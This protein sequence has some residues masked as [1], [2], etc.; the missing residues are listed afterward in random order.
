METSRGERTRAFRGGDDVTISSEDPQMRYQIFVSIP[1]GFLYPALSQSFFF[2]AL[3]FL[4]SYNLTQAAPQDTT[5]IGISS[6]ATGRAFDGVGGLS[7]G[8][9]TSR[10]LWDYPAQQRNEILD[11][12]FKPNY[13][14]SLQILKVEIGDDA[15]STNGAEASHMRSRVD[16]NYNRGYEWWLME[17]AKLRNPNI[18][19]YGLE[20]GGLGWF[21]GGMWS[22]DNINY[23]ISWIK[24]AQSDHNLHINYIGGWNE[25]GW[26]KG[27]FEN[28]KKALQNNGL[29]TQVVAADNGWN[30]AGDLASDSVFKSA[31]DIMGVHYPCG[32]MAPEQNCTDNTYTSVAEGL[33][34]RIWASES[35]SQNYDN[36]AIPLARALN[37]DYIDSRMT[38]YI[39]W[40]LIAA[41]YRTLPYY[42]DGLMLADQPWSGYY[43]VGKSI[44]VMAH[45]AQF[46]QTGWQYVDSGCGYFGGSRA[47]G[48]YVTLKS[49]DNKDYSVIV[50]TVDANA[51]QTATFSVD[52]V[53]PAGAVHVWSTNLNSSNSSD[54]FVQ[55]NDIVPNGGSYSITFQPGY[56]YTLST[57]TGQTKGTAASPASA[58]LGLPYTENFEEDS[59][60]EIPKYF[61]SIQGAFEVDSSR[62]GRS[63]H[64]MRQEI[65][66]APL[67]WPGG[68]PT[69]PLVVVGDPGWSNYVVSTDALLE[70][71]GY[72]DLI[73]HL[74]AQSEGSPGASQGYH[75]RI[76]NGGAWTL[77]KEDISGND[78]QLGSGTKQFLLNS[79]HNFSLWFNADSI[80]AFI[81]SS[82]V[83]AVD[84]G[85]YE[86]GQVGLL[87]SKWQNAEFDNLSVVSTG[88]GGWFSI[89]DAVSGAAVDEFNYVGSGWQHCTECG[90]DLYDESNSWDNVANDF[91]TVSFNSTQ[92]KFYGVRD[93]RHGI[94]AISIDGGAETTID[95]YS[96]T[97]LGNQLL[98]TSPVLP[99]GD[100][101]FKLRVTGNKNPSSSDAWTVPDRVD[102]LEP[103]VTGVLQRSSVPVSYSLFQNYPN[104]FNPSTTIS[105]TLKYNGK[106]YLSVYDILGRE[107]A[108]LANELQA[109]GPHEVKF[110]TAGLSSGIYFYKL[111][112]GGGVLTRKMMLLK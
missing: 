32:W 39:N 45:T 86:S 22:Q 51:P 69:A 30:I 80:R 107:V 34:R 88:G 77:F 23:I 62:S 6:T 101:V 74:G 53:L 26:D 3:L 56:V 17:Q 95:F 89:D 102:I 90:T 108:V 94:G 27:W 85:T 96:A 72:I 64:C 91:V 66:L 18:K 60:G 81:D 15:N 13:G 47:N 52:S 7:G 103:A 50:E 112:S 11:Y 5:D 63:G 55:N 73:G 37:R 68:S 12:L 59:L 82:L 43:H 83:A 70:Q 76:T 99:A 44:W 10:L 92:I 57:S 8:G 97:R 106:V 100:H 40:S 35:G 24:H 98:W 9:G 78:T 111:Q 4:F 105:Y 31:V 1:K 2:C 49:P 54:Y 25:S 61:D 21:N 29:T 19:L 38:A 46:V 79:W 58:S 93:P 75:L 110:S 48:S 33:N 28:L 14:A 16:S 87:T 36:G 71:G 67:E 104:P 65:N 42:G 84:D 20:W 41:W 109:A